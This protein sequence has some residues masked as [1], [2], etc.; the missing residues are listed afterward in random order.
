MRKIIDISPSLH[1]GIAVWPG[2]QGFSRAVALDMDQ[3]DHLTLS[4]ITTTLHLGAH[5]DAPSHT[6]AG[7]PSIDQVPLE[8]YLGL[9]QV[10]ALK[11]PRGERIRP[12]DLGAQLDALQAT[13]VLF[14]TGSFP[15]PD[16]FN[17]DFN[18]LSPELIEAL[19]ERGVVLVGLDTPSVDPF[20]S[21]AL[22]SHAALRRQG[23][24]N[25][26]GLCL[27]AV[28]PGLYELV[29]LP[30]RLVGADASP[31]RAVLLQG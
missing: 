3:G 26:E 7:A 29:A 10:I 8:P 18:S 21:K 27:E 24:V 23:M 25:L 16:H 20:D 12:A 9:C 1:P 4:A 17:E 19:G 2:D 6:G 15:D 5:A 31:I 28:T 11:L 14:Q 22:E 13:R 30:L